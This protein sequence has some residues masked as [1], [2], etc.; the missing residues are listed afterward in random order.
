MQIEKYPHAKVVH[1]ITDGLGLI[2]CLQV[3]RLIQNPMFYMARRGSKG[4]PK[5]G[6]GDDHIC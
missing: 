1:E 5:G 2:L 6:P 4:G 3:R